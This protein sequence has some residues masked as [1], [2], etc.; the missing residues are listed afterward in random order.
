MSDQWLFYDGKQ[1]RL[2]QDG[3]LWAVSLDWE[4]PE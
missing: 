1:W 2:Y 4:G 3:D